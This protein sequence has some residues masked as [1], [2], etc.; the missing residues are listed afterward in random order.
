MDLTP[1]PDGCL[2]LFEEFQRRRV[3]YMIVGLA[4]VAL[5]GGVIATDDLDLWVETLGHPDF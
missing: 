2:K 3:R 4:A 1:F 5:Q